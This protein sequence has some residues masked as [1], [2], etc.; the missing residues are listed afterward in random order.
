MYFEMENVSYSYYDGGAEPIEALSGIGF[1]LPPGRILGV[2]GRTGAGKTT[3]AKI[4]N[5]LLAPTTGKVLVNGAD[6]HSEG[7]NLQRRVGLVCQRPERRLFE[8]TVYNDITFV[9]KR[10]GKFTD[11][12]M[13]DRAEA[14]CTMLN[15][16]IGDIENLQP[17]RMLNIGDRRKVALA[18]ILINDP[19]L[20][21]LDEPEIDL[22]PA[23]IKALLGFIDRFKQ[24]NKSIVVISHN[25]DLFAD[26]IDL[27]LVMDNGAR[28][29]F[30]TP[31][32]VCEQACK[33]P[34]LRTLIPEWI[35]LIHELNSRGLN[36]P[37]NEARPE[38]VYAAVNTALERGDIL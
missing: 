30:G 23:G 11:D 20:L 9:L 19:Q 15:F 16:S 10:A 36:L 21:V 38:S 22:D 33:N 3:L 18:G 37:L 2:I 17:S 35:M 34:D 28:I 32:I 26:L 8:E 27:L 31:Q 12:E 1:S 6:A 25:M 13:R 5:G 29:A 14:A 4:M 7:L 24:E